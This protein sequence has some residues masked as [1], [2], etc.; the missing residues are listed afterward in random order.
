[1]VITYKDGQTSQLSRR[2]LIPA[3]AQRDLKVQPV[4]PMYVYPYPKLPLYKFI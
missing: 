2:R 4:V 1:M 3:V